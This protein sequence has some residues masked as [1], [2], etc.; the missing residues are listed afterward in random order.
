[1]VKETVF[2]VGLYELFLVAYECEFQRGAFCFG[3]SQENEFGF[4]LGNFD[5]IHDFETEQFCVEID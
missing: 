1:M 4:V 5:A 3:V 2:I